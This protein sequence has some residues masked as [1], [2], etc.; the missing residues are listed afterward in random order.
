MLCRCQ[1][2]HC[3]EISTELLKLAQ[4]KAELI[5]S[6]TVLSQKIDAS[7]PDADLKHARNVVGKR[8]PTRVKVRAALSR[9]GSLK[10][11]FVKKK[12][13]L[14]AS[15]V[16]PRRPVRHDCILRKPC[17]AKNHIL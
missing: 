8:P 13:I 4:T 15:S 1:L 10:I 14:V 9:R 17:K 7:N 16:G 3:D 5:R 6:I 12:H 2:A 11:N